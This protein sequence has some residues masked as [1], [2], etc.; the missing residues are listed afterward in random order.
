M[1]AIG[2]A[3]MMTTQTMIQTMIQTMALPPRDLS[4]LGHTD[5]DSPWKAEPRK[6]QSSATGSCASSGVLSCIEKGSDT[7]LQLGER[8]FAQRRATAEQKEPVRQIAGR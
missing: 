1:P 7:G 5:T 4:P 2:A 6:S 3:S 8:Q